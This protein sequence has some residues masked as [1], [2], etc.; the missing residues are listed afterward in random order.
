MQ[1]QRI[2]VLTGGGDCPGLNAVIRAVVKTAISDYGWEVLG[3]EDGFEGLIQPGKIRPLGLGDVRGILPRGGTILGASN[4]AN[5]FAYRVR[6]ADGAVREFNVANDVVTRLQVLGI[7]ALVVIG[8]DGTLHIA[9]ELGS[10][11]APIVAVPKTIDN[12]L[13]G[14]DVTFGFDTAVDTAT[15]ALDKLHSTAESHHRVMILEVM[16]RDAGWIALHAGLAGGADVILIPEIPYHVESIAEKVQA[17]ASTGARFS[18]IVVA[19]GAAPAGGTQVYLATQDPVAGQRL[20]GISNQLAADLASRLEMEVRVT[21]LGH[22]QRGGTP[23]A[24]DRVLATRFG[25]EAVRLIAAGKLDHMVALRGEQLAAIPIA[26]AISRL[27][28]VPLDGDLLR[29]ARSL[30]ICLGD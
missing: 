10:M 29:A 20:G 2:A 3:I 18:V 4:R 14:T 23:S 5:P 8:G 21:I 28:R 27:K 16:G 25:S 17:R 22:V 9:K 12:D 6:G 30:G 26:E 1:A 11:G 15:Q 24:S 19:E 13:A 7:L